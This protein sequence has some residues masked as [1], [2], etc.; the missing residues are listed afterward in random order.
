MSGQVF[1]RSRRDE[2]LVPQHDARDEAFIDR[3]VR[4]DESKAAGK[5]SAS[6]VVLPHAARTGTASSHTYDAA[7][8]E[9]LVPSNSSHSIPYSEEEEGVPP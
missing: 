2:P 4:A 7:L 9:A 6:D 8:A 3:L 5:R 1:S